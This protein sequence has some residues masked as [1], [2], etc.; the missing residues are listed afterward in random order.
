MNPMNAPVP[1]V[2]YG[3]L[4]GD[5]VGLLILAHSDDTVE[6][7]GQKLQQ[8]ARVRAA[9]KATTEVWFKEKILDPSLTLAEAGLEALDRIDVIPKDV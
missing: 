9:P 6:Q 5:T 3:F 8:A 1:I 7:V 2:L 4:Q